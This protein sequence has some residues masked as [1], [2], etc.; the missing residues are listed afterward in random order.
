MVNESRM[1]KYISLKTI[2]KGT[3]EGASR[4]VMLTGNFKLQKW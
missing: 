2:Y 4:S 1:Y 3:K